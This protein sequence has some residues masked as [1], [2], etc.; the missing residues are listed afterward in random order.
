M[1]PV[2]LP[3]AR[4]MTCERNGF[5]VV[6]AWYVRSG[7]LYHCPGCGARVVAAFAVEGYR[8]DEASQVDLNLDDK[9]AA[10][11]LSIFGLGGGET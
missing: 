8:V 6:R 3:C 7:D 11:V 4:E 5:T 2:C 10:D 9:P 1:N